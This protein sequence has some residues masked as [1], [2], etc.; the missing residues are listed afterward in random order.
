VQTISPGSANHELA[1]RCYL[2]R[3][4]ES[5][6]TFGFSDFMLLRLALQSVR[7]VGGFA[8]T[9]SIMAAKFEAIMSN[10]AGPGAA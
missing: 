8:N 3:F 10:S 1:S 6:D 5:A 7:F 2:G 9:S 4:P